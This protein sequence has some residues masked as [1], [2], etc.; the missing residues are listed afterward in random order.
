MFWLRPGGT[1]Y[2]PRGDAMARINLGRVILG[3][4]VAGVVN[5]RVCG[6]G[7][8]SNRL[9]D[10]RPIE[11]PGRPRCGLALRAHPPE[12]RRVSEGR[13]P[14]GPG[15]MGGLLGHSNHGP[16]A[17]RALPEPTVVRRYGVGV[18]DVLVILLS[19]WLYRAA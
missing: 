4:L 19:A 7:Q 9:G 6:A 16:Y 8:D 18:L 2:G 5:G 17:V 13:Q 10:L 3:G 1:N 12:V 15:R 11:L 14:R